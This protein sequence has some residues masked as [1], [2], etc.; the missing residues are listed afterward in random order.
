[1]FLT[2]AEL[3][4]GNVDARPY[5]YRRSLHGP[6]LLVDKTNFGLVLYNHANFFIG[7]RNHLVIGQLKEYQFFSAFHWPT[8]I[9]VYNRTVTE[10]TVRAGNNCNSW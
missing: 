7:L 9:T 4:L 10:N 3:C 8:G 5:A 1:M 2:F 6:P